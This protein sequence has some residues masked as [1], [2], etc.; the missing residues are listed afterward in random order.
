MLDGHHAKDPQNM[1]LVVAAFVIS[2]K[3]ADNCLLGL[4]VLPLVQMLTNIHK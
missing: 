1:I 2:F 4:L 3:K